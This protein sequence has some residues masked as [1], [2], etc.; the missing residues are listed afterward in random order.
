MTILSIG[1]SFKTAPTELLERLAVPHADLSSEV[2]RL[3]SSTA[4]DEVML[5]ST[6][7][8]TEVYVETDASV[9]QAAHAVYHFFA[10][11]AGMSI[12]E[13]C[14]F[15]RVRHEPEAV[16]HLFGVACGLDSMATGEEHVVSQLRTAS[17]VAKAAD[18]VRGRLAP[19]V[20]AAFRAS[21]RARTETAIGTTTPS[22]I[23]AG[24]ELAGEVLGDLSG[25]TALLVGSGAMGSLAGRMLK[26]SGVGEIL[27]WSRT[28]RHATTLAD[29][30]G[31]QVVAANDLTEALG[32][33]EVVVCSTAATQPVITAD[34]LAVARR[35]RGVRPLFCLDLG[36]PRNVDPSCRT[37][38]DVTLVDLEVLGSFLAG[39]GEPSDLD[40]AWKIV[41][42]EASLFAVTR[43]AASVAPLIAALHSRAVTVVDQELSR[44]RQ[45]LPDLDSHTRTEAE[46]S[47]RRAVRKLLH[48]PTVRVKEL[49]TDPDGGL[50]IE[51][52]AQIFDLDLRH[53]S[54][55]DEMSRS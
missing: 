17:R 6:C 3:G 19:L 8:R 48:T 40:A 46:A 29:A 13:V 16:A 45:R 47:V 20:D 1:V 42:E 50:Y 22:L 30:V 51:A 25:R 44:M 31:G 9:H 36:M 14:G 54:A 39:R 18:T 23:T 2:R 11:R 26:E 4:V 28:A 55:P 7:N 41:A 32:R 53:L 15:L 35:S 5:L 12:T 10:A 33:S 49:T 27:V 37:L 24:L 38:E 43:R 34:V 21:K 52:L